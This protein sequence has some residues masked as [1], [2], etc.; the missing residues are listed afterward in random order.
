MPHLYFIQLLF[1]RD[2]WRRF[3]PVRAFQHYSVIFVEAQGFLHINRK[4]VQPHRPRGARRPALQAHPALMKR[5]FQALLF[6][7]AAIPGKTT[8]SV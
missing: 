7:Y 6:L 8:K 4:F 2:N 5:C 1:I 3:L